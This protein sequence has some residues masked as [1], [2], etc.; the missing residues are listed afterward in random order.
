MTASRAW[1]ATSRY[2]GNAA[3]KES[4]EAMASRWVERSSAQ[5]VDGTMLV[6]SA[7]LVDVV[8][9]GI[10]VVVVEDVVVGGTVEVVVDEVVGDVVVEDVVTSVPAAAIRI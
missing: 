9:A 6:G 4:R 2:S 3:A 7:E 5:P 8:V 1:A 10:V